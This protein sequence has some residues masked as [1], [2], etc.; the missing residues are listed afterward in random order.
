MTLY[1]F[2]VFIMTVW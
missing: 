2:V 1:F